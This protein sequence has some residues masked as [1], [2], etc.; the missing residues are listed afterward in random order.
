MFYAIFDVEYKTLM[1]CRIKIYLHKIKCKINGG[2]PKI[3]NNETT[4]NEHSNYY[5]S[6]VFLINKCAPI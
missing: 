6:S 4:H 3:Y 1:D 5:C 2:G